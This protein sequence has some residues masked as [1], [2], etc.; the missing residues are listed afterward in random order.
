MDAFTA[1][2]KLGFFLVVRISKPQVVLGAE[3][4]SLLMQNEPS[5][6]PEANRFSS[7]SQLR[8]LRN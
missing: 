7:R 3:T 2:V 1:M 8:P 6:L 5:Q 4:S